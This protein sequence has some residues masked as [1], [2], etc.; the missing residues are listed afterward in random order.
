MAELTRGTYGIDAGADEMAREGVPE[1]VKPE[2][3]ESLRV[4]AG[5]VRGFVQ[6]TDEDVARLDV[7][8]DEAGAV[9]ASSPAATCSTRPTARS[10]L[11]MRLAT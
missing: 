2:L 11:D 9:A 7:A 5:D 4:Q 3:R 1:V 8:V 10:W 6:P